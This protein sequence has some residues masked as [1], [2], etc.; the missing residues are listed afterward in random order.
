MEQTLDDG[1]DDEDPVGSSS[2]G[3]V[4]TTKHEVV[5]AD[6][7][8]PEIDEVAPEE[9]LEKVGEVMSIIGQLAIVRGLPSEQ[10]NRAAQTALDS[11][12]LLVFDDRKVMGYVRAFLSDS[13]NCVELISD[14][15]TKPLG[16]LRSPSIR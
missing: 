1:D 7:T 15:Y 8:V 2:A 5:E 11:E 13:L 9:Q 3:G 12:T 6:I 10:L 16:Q 4:L 14:R